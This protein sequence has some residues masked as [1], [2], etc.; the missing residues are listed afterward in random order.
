VRALRRLDGVA[1]DEVISIG[2]RLRRLDVDP[3][4]AA[5]GWLRAADLTAAR[6]ALALAGDLEAAL[7]LT[8]ASD[9]TPADARVRALA[10][11]WSWVSDDFCAAR[12]QLL[13]PSPLRA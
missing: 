1:L 8:A 6:V 2:R 10:L 12:E 5:Q 11:L 7:R 4:A 3:L 9:L 13:R